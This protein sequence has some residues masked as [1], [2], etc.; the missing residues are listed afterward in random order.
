[1]PTDQSNAIEQRLKAKTQ[2]IFEK[3]NAVLGDDMAH[4]QSQTQSVVQRE[5]MR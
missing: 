2:S 5:K 4:Y 1:M 3:M